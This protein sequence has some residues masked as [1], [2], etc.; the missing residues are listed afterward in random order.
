MTPRTPWDCSSLPCVE[1]DSVDF[2]RRAR[3]FLR[4][5]SLRSGA[6]WLTFSLLLCSASGWLLSLSRSSLLLQF[7]SR[8][9]L[10]LNAGCCWLNARRCWLFE[11]VL[12]DFWLEGCSPPL[13]RCR[14]HRLC[15]LYWLCGSATGFTGEPRA[16]SP[17]ALCS[18][19]AVVLQ[20]TISI[21]YL[22]ALPP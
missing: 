19:P 11:F 16:A 3:R 2:L 4:D 20:S 1:T 5:S 7:S 9:R 13:P 22:C 10:W 12:A 17:T 21:S 15:W 6:F 8:R 18:S 14:S